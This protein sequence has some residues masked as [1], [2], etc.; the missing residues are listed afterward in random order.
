[1]TSSPTELM[2]AYESATARHDLVATLDLI[3]ADA[4]YWFSDGTSHRGHDAICAVL[5]HN[6]AV[7]SDEHYAIEDLVWLAETP[8][9]AACVYRFA[10]SGVIDGTAADGSGRGTS[11]VAQRGDRWLV[12]HEHL[13][14]GPH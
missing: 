5:E 1:M 10:W 6:F 13:S 9:V 12:V 7:I 4:L 11:V 8:E 2:K 14:S 3:A